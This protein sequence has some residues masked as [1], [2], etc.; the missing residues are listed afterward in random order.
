MTENMN[1]FDRMHEGLVVVS[2]EDQTL[3]FASKPAV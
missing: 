2:E 1:L 3:Q